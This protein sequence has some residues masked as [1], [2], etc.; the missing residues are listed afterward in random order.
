M[1]VKI[2]LKGLKTFCFSGKIGV[3]MIKTLAKNKLAS[4][5]AELKKKHSVFLPLPQ[6]NR[7]DSAGIAFQKASD[8]MITNANLNQPLTMLPPTTFLLPLKEKLMNIE[9]NRYETVSPPP[10]K[11]IVGVGANDV[12][13]INRLDYIFTKQGQDKFYRQRRKKVLIIGINN[14]FH[15]N[16]FHYALNPEKLAGFDVY[17]ELHNSQ[18]YASAGSD[19][20]RVILKSKLF[21][22]SQLPKTAEDKSVPQSSTLNIEK[23]SWAIEKTVNSKVWD[24]WADKCLGCGNCSYVCPLCFCYDI[25]DE[26][27][28]KGKVCRNRQ[29]SSCFL[30]DFDKMSQ[31]FNPRQ[32]FKKRFYHW[33]HHKFVQ[34]PQEYGFSG[35]VNCGRCIKYC[36]AKINFREV[37]NEVIEEAENGK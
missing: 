26:V 23:I 37:L 3:V 18:Y 16:E 4:F 17:L 25:K 6:K 22:D 36:P 24:K 21:S 28:L 5:V 14:G 12:R 31:G 15:K 20:G 10:E 11:A 1:K 19:K 32:D 8:E 27:D 29:Q 7:P 35:C 9:Y 34:M 2:L 30:A 33:Y 13:A